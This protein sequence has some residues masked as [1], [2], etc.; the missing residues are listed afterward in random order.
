MFYTF[1]TVTDVLWV[2]EKQQMDLSGNMRY[3]R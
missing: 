2:K 1:A 3:K